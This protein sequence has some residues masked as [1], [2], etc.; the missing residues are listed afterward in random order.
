MELRRQVIQTLKMDGEAVIRNMSVD[1]PELVYIK[2]VL[3]DNI[4]TQ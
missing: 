4:D 2:R 1:P 3:L